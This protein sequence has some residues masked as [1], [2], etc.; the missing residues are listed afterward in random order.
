[1]QASLEEQSVRWKEY[2]VVINNSREKKMVLIETNIE[3]LKCLL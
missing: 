2:E 3:V 1:M